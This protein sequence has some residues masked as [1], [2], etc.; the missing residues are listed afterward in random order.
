MIRKRKEGLY[1]PNTA[2]SSD[3]LKSLLLLPL[4]LSLF[5]NPGV[6][7]SFSPLPGNKRSVLRHSGASPLIGIT[8]STWRCFRL[9]VS[10]ASP[11]R[12]DTEPGPEQPREAGGL[13][14]CLG[15]LKPTLKGNFT[16]LYIFLYIILH[17]HQCLNV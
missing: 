9:S 11:H 12:T 15:I 14:P 6:S 10:P 2:G 8:G 3:L 7:A 13:S 17:S 5:L 4:S 1:I 16:I